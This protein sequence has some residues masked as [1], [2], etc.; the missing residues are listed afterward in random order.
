MKREFIVERQGRNFVLYAGLL[1]E[2]HTQG[3]KAVRTT[4]LQVPGEENGHVAIVHAAVDTEKGTFTGLGD[5]SPLNVARP[6]VTCLIRMAETRA[7]ARALRDAVNVGV[8]ALEELGNDDDDA[9]NALS[10]RGPSLAPV[11]PT[12]LRRDAT[13]PR[14]ANTPPPTRPATLPT[15]AQVPAAPV[16]GNA[17]TPAQVRAIYTIGRDAHRLSE[18]DVD[19]R[20]QNDY[21][22]RP[23]ALT[24]RQASEFISTLQSSARVS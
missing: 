7:K 17:A 24:K 18:A 11:R 21:G 2:A 1:D 9:D 10:D 3:L 14:P 16:D 4:L 5:A 13:A 8:T 19:A 22:C 15:A 23:E 12:P 6:M 20:C